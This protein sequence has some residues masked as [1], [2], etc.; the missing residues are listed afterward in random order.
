M[1]SPA[2]EDATAGRGGVVQEVRRGLRGAW[3]ES[4]D[5]SREPRF[6]CQIRSG[7]WWTMGER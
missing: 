2:M 3:A 4:G 1:D 7:A 6:C 5:W